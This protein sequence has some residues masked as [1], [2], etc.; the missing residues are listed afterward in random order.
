[1]IKHHKGFTIVEMLVVILIITVLT[2]IGVTAYNGLQERA[3]KNAV[4]SDLQHASVVVEQYALKNGGNF[5]D[6]D[7]LAANFNNTSD[8]NLSIIVDN[9]EVSEESTGPIYTNLTAV[10][11]T[12]LFHEVCRQVISEEEF[13][14]LRSHDGQAVNNSYN[15]WCGSSDGVNGINA[16]YYQI[17]GWNST[18][19][20]MPVTLSQINNRI[21]NPPTD[22]WWN[23]ADLDSRT[24]REIRDRFL[25]V[26]GTF[27]LT[28]A[29]DSWG[30]CAP[31]WAGVWTCN[32]RPREELPVLP[33]AGGGGSDDSS[34]DG[35]SY[36][37]IA[38]HE[39]YTDLL[40]SFSSDNL[41]PKEGN[42]GGTAAV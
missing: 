2:A 29:W 41:A 32:G 7:Y 13:Q 19:W 12:V 27:P 6:N 42:C 28:T 11:N 21:N 40:Y 10:Q 39:R 16:G 17:N 20:N 1:M 35:S 33:P 24:Y 31:N 9:Q 4:L 23:I 22:S 37:I 36:C 15:I 14:I 26:G 38:T 5:P 25:A 34:S 18:R 30:S 8:V 3:A